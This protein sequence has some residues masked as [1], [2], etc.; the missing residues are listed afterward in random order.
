MS[1]K[2]E[3]R[4]S[5]KKLVEDGNQLLTAQEVNKKGV[6][7]EFIA[8]YQNWYTVS[9]RV[10]EVLAI[11]RLEEFISYY[12]KDPK[13]SEVNTYNYVIQDYFALRRARNNSSGSPLFNVEGVVYIRLFNQVKILS[14]LYTRI[15]NVLADIQGT[16]LAELQDQE[17]F[18]AES[19]LKVNLR[20]AGS[21]A[22][23]VLENHL[24]KVAT[25]HKVKLI[26]ENPTISDVNDLLKENKVYDLPT[27]RKIQLL[28]DIRNICSHKKETEP[29]KEQVIE[30]IAGVNEI[31]KKIV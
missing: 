30:L 27:W 26:K 14:S 20:A 1:N 15:D 25:Y 2:D 28:G 18:T 21:L 16:M 22:R 12:L 23:V 11:D 17:L 7:Q 3:L 6:S 31:I 5:L 8:E 24:Q 13:R 29:Q 9:L 19:L 4:A 10:V